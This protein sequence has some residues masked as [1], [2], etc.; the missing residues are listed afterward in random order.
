MESH[1]EITTVQHL[2]TVLESA[3]ATLR[4]AR[5]ALVTDPEPEWTEP[6]ARRVLMALAYLRGDLE[7]ALCQAEKLAG[8][9][10]LEV[11]QVVEPGES[12]EYPVEDQPTPDEW[13]PIHA[14]VVR[15]D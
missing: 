13:P 10:Y 8:V 15:D 4:A 11:H 9:E 12:L 3:E 14:D 6:Q 1:L 5:K 2:A 7:R